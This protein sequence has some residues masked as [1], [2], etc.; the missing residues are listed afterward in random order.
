MKKKLFFGLLASLLAFSLVVGLAGCSGG[1]TPSGSKE[2]APR[3]SNY[4]Q[5]TSKG[6]LQVTFS[7]KSLQVSDS[8]G[9]QTGDNYVIKLNGTEISRGKVT[10]D[11]AKITY[12][13]TN[14]SPFDGY[15]SAGMLRI[16]ALPL[17]EGGT[18][19]V[20]ATPT[21]TTAPSSGGGGGGSSSS[22]KP[23]KPVN[24]VVPVPQT[25]LIGGTGTGN[26]NGISFSVNQVAN[27]S[28]AI[29]AGNGNKI[30]GRVNKGSKYYEL[31]GFYDPESGNYSLSGGSDSEG[32]EFNGF[33]G[34]TGKGKFKSKEAGG[35]W[36]LK[37]FNFNFDDSLF[38]DGNKENP[39]TSLPEAFWGKWDYAKERNNQQAEQWGTVQSYNEYNGRVYSPLGYLVLGPYNM[40][41]WF[42][43][44]A[45]ES[46]YNEF[47]DDLAS[48][49]PGY[50]DFPNQSRE[51]FL[52]SG[53]ADLS[54]NCSE[55]SG[56]FTILEVEA[57]DANTCK[58]VLLYYD[59][60]DYWFRY[61]MFK[62]VGGELRLTL[63]SDP[64]G[65]VG[66]NGWG[67]PNAATVADAKELTRFYDDRTDWENGDNYMM[68][69]STRP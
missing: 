62:L 41:F 56:S 7:N 58:A 6:M 64:V 14:G 17:K 68:L 53:I 34:S 18:L 51:D 42:D 20:S 55:R 31:K 39:A 33:K 10:V 4:Y 54:R 48:N 8:D 5:N 11:G 28:R 29:G 40:S 15:L 9:P 19:V 36:L 25:S 23:V 65:S 38:I 16:T 57:V 21:G 52:A 2:E 44:R 49:T 59:G 60:T 26:G 13:P 30:E 35:E 24:P 12:T 32:F 46:F 66:A 67:N 27:F 47:A 45:I 63:G 1:S 3:T 69:V 37:E 61:L 22:N 50:F 43:E